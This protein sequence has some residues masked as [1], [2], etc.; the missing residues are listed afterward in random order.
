MFAEAPSASGRIAVTPTQRQEVVGFGVSLTESTAFNL[1]AIDARKPGTRQF[2]IDQYFK[3]ENANFVLTRLHIGSCDFTPTRYSYA[4]TQTADLDNFS[5]QHDV[6]QGT[7]QLILDAQAA[8]GG[9]GSLKHVAS[10]WTAPPWMKTGADPADGGYT[11]GRLNPQF[12]NLFG[13]YIARYVQAYAARGIPIW[14]VTPQNEPLHL[15]NFETMG[16]VGDGT[17]EAAFIAQSLGP[18]MAALEPPVKILGFDHNKGAGLAPFVSALYG[19]AEAARHLAGVA[20]H[21]YDLPQNT[22][23]ETLD[24]AHNISRGGLIIGTEQG[25]SAITN[26][27]ANAAWNNDAWWWGPNSPDWAAGGQGHLTVVGV[28]RVAGDIIQSFNHWQQGWIYWNAVGDKY[29]GPSHFTARVPGTRAQSPIAVDVGSTFENANFFDSPPASPP[30]FEVYVTPTFY[31][32]QHF[33]KF[34]LPGGRVLVS[35]VEAPLVGNTAVGGGPDFM[36]LAALNPNGSLAVVVLNEKSTPVSYQITVG[37][38][39]VPLTIPAAALQTVLL[40]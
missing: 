18:K 9:A 10:P 11:N 34:V 31:V 40:E 4:P 5:V 38:Q 37:S 22:F 32:L 39:S 35:N 33:S 1:L 20:T 36:A 8:A 21:W 12:Y 25:L 28:Y 26:P 6:D 23:V 15:G 3:P 19:N 14:A 29:G 16:F 13:L 30:T 17:G 2:I 27:V 7:V 24:A